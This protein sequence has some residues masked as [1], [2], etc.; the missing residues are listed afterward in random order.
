MEK[1]LRSRYDQSIDVIKLLRPTR[2]KPNELLVKNEALERLSGVKSSGK[3]H[4]SELKKSIA[5]AQKCNL[6]LNQSQREIEQLYKL[7]KK[8]ADQTMA[9]LEVSR[10]VSNILPFDQILWK[11]NSLISQILGSVKC[12]LY[13]L[14]QEKRGAVFNPLVTSSSIPDFGFTTEG[15][16]NELWQKV[17]RDKQPEF[18]SESSEI[19]DG[20]LAVPLVSRGSVIGVMIIERLGNGGPFTQEEVELCSGIAGPVA[21]SIE[22]RSL[23]EKLEKESL[24]LKTALLSLKVM[25]DN[26]A[27]L[28]QGVEP[29]LHAIGESLLQIT[30]AQ[31]AMILTRTE[32][33]VSVHVPQPFPEKEILDCYFSSWMNNVNVK[34]FGCNC[35]ISHQ[36]LK[37]D[38]NLEFLVRQYSLAEIVV[39]PM[40]MRDKVLG[41]ILL[42]FNKYKGD[43]GCQSIL[44]ILGNQ[45]AIVLENARL[46][47]DTVHLKNQAES[48]F[49]I[50]CKQKEQL[51]QKNQELKNMYN[52]LF[53]SREEQ[54]LSQER[55][56]IAR[57]L[58]DNVLQIL[59]AI[60]LHFQW[61]FKELSE[62]SPVF[63]K[64]KFLDDLVHKAVQE[65]RQ[66]IGEFST[67]ETS[68]SLEESIE[69]LVRDLNEVSSVHIYVNFLGS[70]S[71][72]P[73]VVRNIAYRII[74]EGLVNALR[75]AAATQIHLQLSF[76]G[77]NLVIKIIDNGIG[78]S[79]DT[80]QNLS[81]DKKKFG[82]K[83]ML[84]R[85][86][87][88]NGTLK[89]HKQES[90]GTEILVTIPMGGD[91]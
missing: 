11:T 22:N 49:L 8:K 38:H 74:Q 19:S 40:I 85:A 82:L 67:L 41:L 28:N 25:S 23:V 91:D 65:I 15:A 51:E 14:R 80:I 63:A 16:G 33:L 5:Q 89:I 70:T 60:G 71:L 64:L 50:A 39:F 68:L 48:H 81:L 42:Y 54:I 34:D 55:N 75:H 53:R 43:E 10:A 90:G 84:Q 35:G 21:V 31:Y 59:F 69:S 3:T 88:L 57:D 44:Q 72:L 9:I 37:D 30:D 32:K 47:E 24:R 45:T 77:E 87:Y 18:I 7:L 78:I 56:R 79:E 52:I 2:N 20:F 29:L 62:Q 83:N 1:R 73:N 12:Y 36:I 86:Q 17:I 27:M 46:F 6:N 66:V 58:H 76:T 4:Y 61:C 26:L 13:G